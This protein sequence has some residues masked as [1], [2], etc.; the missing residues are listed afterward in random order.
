LSCVVI[1]VLL[2]EVGLF[3]SYRIKRLELS[4]F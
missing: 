2:G 4:R 3:L 1:W